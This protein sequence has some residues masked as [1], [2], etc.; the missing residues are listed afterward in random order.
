MRTSQSHLCRI[1]LSCLQREILQTFSPF[2]SS[3][4]FIFSR[5]WTVSQTILQ[6]TSDATLTWKVGNE[7]SNTF[8]LLRAFFKK[9]KPTN[10]SNVTDITFCIT[11]KVFHQ[12]LQ[13]QM[14][15]ENRCDSYCLLHLASVGLQ[16]AAR[17]ATDIAWGKRRWT[18]KPVL[19]FGWL[20]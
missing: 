14:W 17:I 5:D 6:A 18:G 12:R 8:K 2:L 3:E 4:W 13:S 16:P 11:I 15:A 10:Q 7:G 9:N 20:I 1:L 19:E